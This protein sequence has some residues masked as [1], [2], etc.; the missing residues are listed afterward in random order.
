MWT[1]YPLPPPLAVLTRFASPRVFRCVFVSL[2]P[3][4]HAA[5]RCAARWWLAGRSVDSSVRRAGN[6]TDSAT[7][8]ALAA[9]SSL[10]AVLRLTE[11]RQ[12]NKNNTT[13]NNHHERTWTHRSMQR[14][15]TRGARKEG[16]RERAKEKQERRNNMGLW[17]S[18]ASMEAKTER[19]LARLPAQLLS[20]TAA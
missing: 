19:R 8:T 11:A 18:V 5:L 7:H 13:N 17:N 9:L 14:E 15:Q 20:D 1:G 6:T 16:R 10:C 12:P 2:D 3:P 4:R